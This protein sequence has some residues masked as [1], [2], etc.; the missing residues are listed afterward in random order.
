MISG[1]LIQYKQINPQLR[2]KVNLYVGAVAIV[3]IVYLIIIAFS[4]FSSVGSTYGGDVNAS[5]IYYSGH[6]MLTFDDGIADSIKR[7]LWGDFFIGSESIQG[8]DVDSMLGTHFGSRFFTY[9]GGFYL[10]FG[11]IFTYQM[12]ILFAFSMYLFLW[13]YL[14]MDVA[15]DCLGYYVL[16][17]I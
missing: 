7:Y 10:D 5:L 8:K 17:Y 6:S 2:V 11:P 16:C 14:Y 12:R 13:E 9:I 15:M 1:Y 3:F 4:R